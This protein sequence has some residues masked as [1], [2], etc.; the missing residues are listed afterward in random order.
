MK[1]TRILDSTSISSIG[2]DEEKNTLEVKFIPAGTYHYFNVQASMY[3]ALLK[4]HSK[5]EFV[6]KFIKPR[7]EYKKI[8]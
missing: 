3:K 7:Y 1:R 6:N 2:Y 5:G 4:S 8:N